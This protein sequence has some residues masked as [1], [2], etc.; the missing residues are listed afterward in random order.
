MFYKI[1]TRYGTVNSTSDV[2]KI[3]NSHGIFT[4]VA[5]IFDGRLAIDLANDKEGSENR[6][7]AAAETIRAFFGLD[8]ITVDY[9]SSK[10]T[11][12]AICLI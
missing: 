8:D 1:Y 4:F 12:Q 2:R 10:R 9:G 5:Q 11:I 7:M 3:L 6:V